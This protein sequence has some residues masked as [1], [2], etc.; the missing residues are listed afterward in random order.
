[1]KDK[2]KQED[3]LNQRLRERNKRRG[4]KGKQDEEQQMQ[5]LLDKAKALIDNLDN[6]NER[7]T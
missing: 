1:M 4:N 3:D 5:E 2:L 7:Q 6:L